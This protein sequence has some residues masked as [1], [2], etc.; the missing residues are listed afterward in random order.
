MPEQNL[1]W[2]VRTS[3]AVPCPFNVGD[4]LV[5]EDPGRQGLVRNGIYVLTRFSDR[6]I[7]VFNSALPR[8]DYG[9]Y[10][11]RFRPAHLGDLFPSLTD[12]QRRPQYGIEFN[13]FSNIRPPAGFHWVPYLNTDPDARFWV[14]V[15][16]STGHGC[17]VDDAS[18]RDLPTE[19]LLLFRLQAIDA[20]LP[21]PPQQ[22]SIVSRR[23]PANIRRATIT[24]LP[25]P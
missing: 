13:T 14:H 16:A 17:V 11:D 21:P 23:P 12:N 18:R 7:R 25:L 19:R 6:H 5:C 20:S 10:F 1:C 22:P 24:P 2:G 4:I 15:N 9:L 8:T 3:A